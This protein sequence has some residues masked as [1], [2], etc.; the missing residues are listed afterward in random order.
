[1][2]AVVL[3]AAGFGA[4]GVDGGLLYEDR[5]DPAVLAALDDM[6]VTQHEQAS[7]LDDLDNH[8]DRTVL[9]RD[10]VLD[11][12][13]TALDGNP[14]LVARTDTGE[15]VVV[16]SNGVFRAGVQL[17]DTGEAALADLVRRLGPT[18]A[19]VTI[20]VVGHTEDAQVSGSSGYTTNAELGMARA[21]TAAE[22]MS[23]AGELPLSAFSLSSSGASAPPFPSTTPQNRAKNRTVTVVVRPI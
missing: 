18:V 13:T 3:V 8:L 2:L 9:H 10:R 22:L 21:T 12:L 4:A 17:S 6:H 23:T 14:A 20:T 19:D 15:V 1:M 7:R 11:A 16:F 5:P